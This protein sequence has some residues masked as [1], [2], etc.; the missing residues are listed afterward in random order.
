MNLTPCKSLSSKFNEIIRRLLK[1]SP[2]FTE[3]AHIITP[4]N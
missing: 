3:A 2:Q 4:L 1:N